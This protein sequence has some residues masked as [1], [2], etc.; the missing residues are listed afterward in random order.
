MKRIDLSDNNDINYLSWDSVEIYNAQTGLLLDSDYS[1]AVYTHRPNG[2]TYQR[3][4]WQFKENGWNYI[5]N[6]ET[7]RFLE[8]NTAGAIYTNVFNGGNEQLWM[9]WNNRLVNLAN[10]L[11]LDSNY[12]S[13]VYM[14]GDNGGNYQAWYFRHL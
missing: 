9:I 14:L 4:Q 3:W 5:K 1:G 13:H 2:G 10:G 7:G 8:S 12:E 6:K 11:A